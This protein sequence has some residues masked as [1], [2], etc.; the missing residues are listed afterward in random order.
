MESLVSR[1]IGKIAMLH[2]D[3]VPPKYKEE[4]DALMQTLEAIHGPKALELVHFSSNLMTL[5]SMMVNSSTLN[6]GI[7]REAMGEVVDNLLSDLIE[8]HVQALGLSTEVGKASVQ[9]AQTMHGIIKQYEKELNKG[10]M[11]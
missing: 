11:K 2:P 9:T 8:K 7:T 10:R 6:K 4:L 1:E 5:I 3:E